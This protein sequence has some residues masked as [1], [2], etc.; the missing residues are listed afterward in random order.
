MK[1]KVVKVSHLNANICNKIS[2]NW[3]A[4][5][6]CIIKFGVKRF[7]YNPATNMSG[8]NKCIRNTK[9]S[10]KAAKLFVIFTLQI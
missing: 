8:A 3:L 6:F 1:M 4:L 7:L 10:A 5:I 9:L 2:M